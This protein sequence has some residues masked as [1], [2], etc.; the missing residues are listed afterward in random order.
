MLLYCYPE[1]RSSCTEIDVLKKA[2]D[3]QVDMMALGFQ[4]AFKTN[5]YLPDEK[6]VR[7]IFFNGD[8]HDTF[9]K[10]K[11]VK[12]ITISRKEFLKQINEDLQKE[13][14]RYIN[15][16]EKA[17][18]EYYAKIADQSNYVYTDRGK[19]LA[20]DLVELILEGQKVQVLDIEDYECTFYCEQDGY[21][22]FAVVT[23][24]NENYVVYLYD[25]KALIAEKLNFDVA[26]RGYEIDLKEEAIYSVVSM[27]ELVKDGFAIT[28]HETHLYS[29]EFTIDIGFTYKGKTYDY[30]LSSD[31]GGTNQSITDS[32]EIGDPLDI[33]DILCMDRDDKEHILNFLNKFND[34]SKT[35]QQDINK[36]R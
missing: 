31:M 23:L 22:E 9:E 3:I 13:M 8:S 14:E 27:A 10:S 11:K 21:D 34:W 6:F 24:G 36:G 20:D 30:Y 18:Q 35:L 2:W 4:D 15:G 5:G 32:D 16:G 12:D 19:L 17:L 33:D 1:M 28:N 29:D 7:E 25:D 26:E